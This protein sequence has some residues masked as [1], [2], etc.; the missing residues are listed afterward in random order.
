MKV[1]KKNINGQF[2]TCEGKVISSKSLIGKWKNSCLKRYRC[3]CGRSINRTK[4][5]KAMAHKTNSKRNYLSLFPKW[6][7]YIIFL[8]I[9]SNT[10]NE[11]K[12]ENLAKF[13][14]FTHES[15]LIMNNFHDSEA[16]ANLIMLEIS[17]I[18]IFKNDDTCFQFLFLLLCGDIELNPG[19]N[20][21]HIPRDSIHNYKSFQERGLHF[22]HLNINSLLPKIDEI[23]LLALNSKPHLIS[24]SETKLD[25][26]ILD[27]EIDVYGYSMIR[28]DRS[29][30]GGGVAC[31]VKNDI[32][33]NRKDSFSNA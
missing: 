13:D 29:R 28:S 24:L 12:I 17:S 3:H 9:K 6:Y 7:A 25:S 8:I 10:N 1:I 32:S 33:F 22:V 2:L 15:I 19:P 21:F 23:R 20:V 30:N 31:Y 4:I 14:F 26:T 11:I 5:I 16:G 18:K 27:E